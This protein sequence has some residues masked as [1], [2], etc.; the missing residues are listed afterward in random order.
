MPSQAVFR[1][2]AARIAL[3]LP[4]AGAFALAA[5]LAASAHVHVV[6][7]QTPVGDYPTLQFKVPTESSTAST[8]G[9]E[10]DFPIDHPFTS[11][12]YQ[13]LPGWKTVVVESRLPTPVKAEG[14]TITTA[15]TKVVW[16]A[17]RGAGI[18]PGAFELFTVSAGAVPDTG[19]VELPTTQTYSDG[20]V[21]KWNQAAGASGAEP[22]HPAPVLYIT[23]RPPADAD[24]GVPAATAVQTAGEHASSPVALGL[25]IGGLGLGALALVVAVAA[26]LRGGA[27]RASRVA[28]AS[29]ASSEP[30]GS[31]LSAPKAGE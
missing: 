3:A 7:E 27:R 15:V 29:A 31:A 12:S 21:V 18:P 9:L 20:S 19:R 23:D 4:L 1:A 16:T 8:V 6:P 13:P 11:V 10:V 22:E 5:P 28:G 14:G 17:E 25:G 2:A 24:Q 30:A 26:Y